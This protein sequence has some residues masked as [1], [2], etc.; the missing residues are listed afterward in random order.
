MLHWIT[1]SRAGFVTPL[2]IAFVLALGVYVLPALIAWSI[3]SPYRVAI[4]V[5]DVLLGWTVLGWIAA[6][7]WVVLSGDD[8]SFD[9][10]RPQRR[11]PWM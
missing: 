2:V 5:L 9:E 6:L 7:I 3:G 11:E 4:T 1:D 10:D 8:G